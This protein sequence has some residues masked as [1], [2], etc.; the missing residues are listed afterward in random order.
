MKKQFVGIDIAMDSFM[1]AKRI[2]GSTK[3]WTKK[4]DYKTAEDVANFIAEQ[5]GQNLH[6]VMEFTSIYHKRLAYSLLQNDFMV[7][8]VDSKK[9]SNYIEMKSRGTKTDKTDACIL[10]EYGENEKPN[11]YKLPTAEYENRKQKNAHLKR[12]KKQLVETKNRL[13][14]YEFE[15][16]KDETVRE[17]L[18]AQKNFFEEQIKKL[19]DALKITLNAEDQ[20]SIANLTTI[21]G[22]GEKTATA[23]VQCV[24]SMPDFDEH[25][26][27][28]KL[29]KNV[30]LAP[31]VKQSGKQTK[32][33][34][35]TS[36][37]QKDLKTSLYMGA[38]SAV[39]PRVKEDNVFR[40]FY[41]QLRERGKSYNEALVATMHKMIRVAFAVIKT[42]K[43]FDP[44]YLASI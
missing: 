31:S 24:K 28:K 22:V 38:K 42:G 19:E 21:N 16:F 18:E 4:Y 5:A 14:N 33:S 39:S 37:G 17:M 32:K 2:E 15:V 1:V 26:N 43:P 27:S 7:S 30:G 36:A 23:I 40:T 12:V 8:L 29:A 44:N 9:S 35:L 6:F 10:L 34:S 13:H 3:F 11:E 41:R 20:K 25:K